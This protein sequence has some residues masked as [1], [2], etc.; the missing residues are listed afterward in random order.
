MFLR[1]PHSKFSNFNFLWN[2]AG[3]DTS[4]FIISTWS[5]PKLYDQSESIFTFSLILIGWICCSSETPKVAGKVLGVMGYRLVPLFLLSKEYRRNLPVFKLRNS[6]STRSPISSRATCSWHN[7][8]Y[9][10]GWMQMVIGTKWFIFLKQII[11]WDTVPVM[12]ILYNWCTM[13]NST[14][15]VHK[16]LLKL[17][18]D[19]LLHLWPC[20]Y[21]PSPPLSG[22]NCQPFPPPGGPG[23]PASK[24]AS[25]SPGSTHTPFPLSV[26]LLLPI[27]E[28]DKRKCKQASVNSSY[29]PKERW[30]VKHLVWVTEELQRP[31]NQTENLKKVRRH[32][33]LLRP[34]EPYHF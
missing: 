24:M 6:C 29:I 2:T 1:I 19:R 30:I 21:V 5:F 33:S 28:T 4:W 10:K 8:P 32:M 7:F 26:T 27:F 16:R 17:W 31:N 20:C 15:S 9:I 34:I 18:Q 13:H 22:V 25:F 12:I 23:H 14:H 11:Q 3:V